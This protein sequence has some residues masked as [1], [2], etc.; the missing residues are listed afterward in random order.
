M[1]RLDRILKETKKYEKTREK[2]GP[3]P[4]LRSNRDKTRKKSIPVYNK[5]GK[6]I[7]P[8]VVGRKRRIRM[9]AI[10][11]GSILLVLYAPGLFIREKTE[12]P[13]SVMADTSAIRL[14]N[15]VLRSSPDDDFDGDGLTNGI[16]MEHSTNPWEVDTD[17]DGLMDVYEVNSASSDPVRQDNSAIIDIQTRLDKQKGKTMASPYKIEN[18]ILWADDYPSKARGSIVETRRGYHIC[19]FNGYVQF[20]KEKGRYAYK[21]ENGVHKPLPYKAEES[22]WHVQSGDVIEIYDHELP[23][24]VRLGIFAKY[25]YF[26][27]NKVLALLSAILP[28]KGIFSA[29]EMTRVDAE[30]DTTKDVLV[31]ITRPAFDSN[32]TYRFTV[33][34][35]SLDGYQYVLSAIEN[36]KSCIAVSLFNKDRGEY[37]G[38]IYGYNKDGDFYVADMNTMKHVGLLHITERARKI[39]DEKGTIISQLYFDFEGLGYSSLAGDRISFFAASGDGNR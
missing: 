34:T 3:M 11:T 5:Q 13:V 1:S 17:G 19:G 12:I 35:V 26:N 39:V 23:P 10:I 15:S 22:T 6:T 9:A 31:D 18:V 24:V 32:D 16:E 30:P 4:S 33:N 8:S 20:P 2:N 29:K 38:I 28:E 27:K 21:V 37:K 25:G 36:D 7:T 14:S